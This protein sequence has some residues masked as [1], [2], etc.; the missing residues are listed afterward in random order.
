[1]QGQWRNEHTVVVTCGKCKTS[2]SEY[3]KVGQSTPRLKFDFDNA[4]IINKADRADY[5]VECSVELLLNS[6]RSTM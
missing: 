5:M 4:D 2:L 6:V 3:V 1:M